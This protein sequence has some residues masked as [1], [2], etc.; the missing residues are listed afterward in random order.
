M[1]CHDETI[2]LAEE[3]AGW[4]L[5]ISGYSVYQIEFGG[6]VAVCASGRR[7]DEERSAPLVDLIFNS[8][9]SLQEPSGKNYELDAEGP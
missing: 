9:F 7:E 5:P 8:R 1:W 3:P 4:T 2:E 6:R